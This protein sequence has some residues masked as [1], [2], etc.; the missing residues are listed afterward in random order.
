[1]KNLSISLCARLFCGYTLV[2]TALAT[3]GAYHG[4]LTHSWMDFSHVSQFQYTIL[5]I[6][7]LMCIFALWLVM[8]IRTQVAAF[9]SIILITALIMFDAA[10]YSVTGPTAVWEFA[11]AA[12]FLFSLL[13]LIVQGVVETALVRG[14]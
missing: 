6:V 14:G 8:G 1:M 11:H 10:D 13:T 4:P 9:F 7:I 12:F 5:P 3:L 2:M